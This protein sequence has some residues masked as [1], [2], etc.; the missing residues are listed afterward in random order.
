MSSQQFLGRCLI[1]TTII[2]GTLAAQAKEDD[3]ASRLSKLHFDFNNREHPIDVAVLVRMDQ[4]LRDL[5]PSINE[6]DESLVVGYL[7]DEYEQLGLNIN[8]WAP[9]MQY[10]GLLLSY[11]HAQ[12]PNSPFRNR[13][14]FS[15]IASSSSPR[16][17]F[18]GMPNIDIAYQYIVEFP[19]GPFIG[20]VYEILATFYDDFYKTFRKYR[21]PVSGDD[22]FECF[23]PYL[24][25]QPY[26]DQRIQTE[27]L[28]IHFYESALQAFRGDER[29]SSKAGETYARFKE[30]LEVSDSKYLTWWY[31]CIPC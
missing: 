27:V 5:V 23:E 17:E 22:F 2:F 3:L 13:T 11:A 25:K 28:A 12:D 7:L 21:G 29:R 14:L 30:I 31:W 15:A 16:S 26:R 9:V 6:A 19:D 10:S 18:S 1:T 24:T 8:H 4:E 20:D